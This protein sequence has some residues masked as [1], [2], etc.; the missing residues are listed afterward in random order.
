MERLP[1][2]WLAKDIFRRN[3]YENRICLALAKPGLIRFQDLPIFGLREYMHSSVINIA[4]VEDHSDFRH[5]LAEAIQSSP[6]M[7]VTGMAEDVD[8]GLALLKVARP[9]VLL[10]D[11]GLPSG[12]GLMLIH[13]ARRRWGDACVCAVLTMTGNESH[14]FKAIRAGARG[15]LFKSDDEPMWVAGVRLLANG[16]GLMLNSLAK[17]VLNVP[18]V[19]QDATVLAVLE[20]MAAG[21]SRVEVADRLALGEQEIA[22]QICRCYVRIQES[23]PGL[24]SREAELLAML[25]GGVVRR[26]AE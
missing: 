13:E 18:D 5:A 2:N 22:N 15:Y 21:Y 16:G 25:D 8:E 20:L 3:Q 17:H 24:S 12:S 19:K 9:D 14:L 1:G 6:G 26:A 4:I 10:V 7:V 11:L 23:T